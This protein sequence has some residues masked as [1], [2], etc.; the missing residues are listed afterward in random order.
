V[1]IA[2]ARQHLA[3]EVDDFMQRSSSPP[4]QQACGIETI[5]PNFGFEGGNEKK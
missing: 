2:A 1:S 5:K 3:Q 4:P